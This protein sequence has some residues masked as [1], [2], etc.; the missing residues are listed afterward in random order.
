MDLPKVP[1]L[2]HLILISKLFRILVEVD[3]KNHHLISIG[4]PIEDL[5]NP[6]AAKLKIEEIRESCS[7]KK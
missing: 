6:S 4:S 2:K 1:S 7:Y 5:D 3:N